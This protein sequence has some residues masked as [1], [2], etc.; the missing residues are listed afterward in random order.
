[1]SKKFRQCIQSSFDV[2]LDWK[3]DDKRFPREPWLD[4]YYNI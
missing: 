1:M 4:A 2:V 3:N